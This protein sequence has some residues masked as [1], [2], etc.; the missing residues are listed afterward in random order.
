MIVAGEESGDMRAAA[1]IRAIKGYAPQVQFF[2]IA[3]ERC[4]KEGV[5][6]FADITD[7]AVIGFAEVLKHLSRIKKVFDHAVWKAK[8]E[9]P[10]IAILV[11]YPGF[12]LRLARELKKLGIKVVY[13][14]SPQ[15]W[16]WKAS[17]V[18]LIK[19]CVDRML[20]LFPFEEEFYAKHGYKADFVGHPLLDEVRADRRPGDLLNSLGLSEKKPTLTLL[21]GSR[22]KEITRHLPVM[23]KAAALLQKKHPRLQVILLQAKNIPDELFRKYLK[24]SSPSIKVT[25]DYYNSLNCADF[26][27]VA[28]GTATLE[29]AI[30]GKP[31]AVIYRTSWPTWLIAKLVIRIPH[32]ALVNIVAGKK[33][34]E[35]LIQTNATPQKIADAISTF[36][37]KPEQARNIRQE[38]TSIRSKLGTSGASQRAAKIVISELPTK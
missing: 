24:A 19:K 8:E 33:I 2:G 23:L 31:M 34:V 10:D 36:L 35:E 1:L 16:A 28:S 15:V 32:I 29:T 6:T 7:L 4:R 38:L 11:D 27:V 13:Y 17:R 14:V 5:D 22:E 25:K 20:V 26:C 18:K 37:T 3:G 30:M 21:P 9:R 12:N